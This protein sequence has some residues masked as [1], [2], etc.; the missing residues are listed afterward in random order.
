MCSPQIME[1]VRSEISR[2]HVLGMAGAAAMAG[3]AGRLSKAAA[4]D[5]TPVVS[6]GKLEI[7]LG[8]YTRVIDLTHTL[9]PTT[10][11]YPGYPQPA[12]EP[13]K[14]FEKDGFYANKLTYGEHSGTHMDAPAHFVEGAVTADDLPVERF[15]AP[16]AVVD[17]S[18]RAETDP[19]T[20]VMPDDILAWEAANGPL[21]TGAFVA[22][23]SGWETRL[24]EPASFINQDHEGVLHFPGFHPDATALLVEERD[25]TGIGVDTLSLDYGASTDFGSH[26]TLLQ[27]GRY[28]LE[29][30][31]ALGAVPAAGALLI[32]G[33]P[34][35]MIASGG[36]T[37]AMALA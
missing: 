31:A 22:M 32:V 13:L 24:I 20:Q 8:S 33:G 7:A 17:V 36:P 14:T 9:T 12:I 15:F 2:R 10:P 29:G 35:V 27:S 3:L 1:K 6:Q 18:A 16:L 30:L 23:Y 28:G 5:A 25:I 37:R 4:Q 26:V 34:K 21:P 11:L 19:D